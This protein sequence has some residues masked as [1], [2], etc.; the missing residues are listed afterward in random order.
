[1]MY[2]PHEKL[3]IQWAP[4]DKRF[5]LSLPWVS[6][7]VKVAE[8]DKKWVK[9]ATEHLHTSASNQNV[10]KFMSKLK[11]YPIFYLQ[12]RAFEEFNEND[13]QICPEIMV[14]SSTPL[15][16]IETFGCEIAEELK[17]D[18]LPAWTWNWE[19]ILDHSRIANTDLYDPLSFISYLLCYRLEWENITWS[20]QDGF[21]KFLERLLKEDEAQFFQVMGW[22]VKQSWY[23]TSEA[24]QVMEPA[25]IHFEKAREWIRQYIRDEVGHHKFMEKVFKDLNL[26]KNAFP[27]GAAT[28][29]QLDA[30]GRVSSLSPLAFSALINLFEATFY[31]GEDP[32]SRLLRLSSKPQAANGYDL[33]YKIN[34]DNRHCDMPLQLGAYLGPQTYAHASLTLGLFELTLN[35]FDCMEKNLAQRLKMC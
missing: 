17:K 3:S 5:Y 7:G 26:D 35:F 19:K 32:I 12:P 10:Q 31:E 9:D 15:T 34:Q 25:L 11:D 14:D 20:G 21:G 30:F 22:V 28:Q 8:E 33:H 18:I 4:D 24:C 13:L 6:L 29:W 2:V 1:M 27:V 23:I 16:L